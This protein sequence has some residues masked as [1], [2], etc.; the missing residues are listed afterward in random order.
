MAVQI[1]V[2]EDDPAI[3][4]TLER[5]LNG[6][7]Y[8]VSW[9]RTATEGMALVEPATALVILDLGLPDA[10]GLD[11]C[12]RLQDLPI[13]PQVLVLTARAGEADIVLGLDAGADDY[14]TKPFRLAELLAGVRACTRRA[15]A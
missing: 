6:Q 7:G 4:S 2:I 5:T 15:Q 11:V 9:G 13:K 12:R 3:G 10:D 8:E 1:V 14:L